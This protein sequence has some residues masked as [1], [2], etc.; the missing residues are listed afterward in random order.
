MASPCSWPRAGRYRALGGHASA[1]L[2]PASLN[3]MLSL[4][5][6]LALML[7]L[8]VLF[9]CFSCRVDRCVCARAACASCGNRCETRRATQLPTADRRDD[10]RVPRRART[11]TGAGGA[12]PPRAR[13]ASWRPRCSCGCSSR[14]RCCCACAGDGAC[15]RAGLRWRCGVSGASC[16]ARGGRGAL[17]ASGGSGG[18]SGRR[19]RQQRGGWAVRASPV[20]KCFRAFR[21]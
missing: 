16:R 10:G 7:C 8:A 17:G 4:H 13:C 21:Q 14:R 18:A 11:R 2:W 20:K 3:D 19:R 12:A 1:L 15:R 6:E 5:G 9:L